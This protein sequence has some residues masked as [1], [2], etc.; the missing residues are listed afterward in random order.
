MLL[1]RLCSPP[2]ARTGLSS[3][4]GL[5]FLSSEHSI[6][7]TRETR[8]LS[9]VTK[10]MENQSPLLPEFA[11]MEESL[12]ELEA[13]QW[14]YD[15]TLRALGRDL[16][17]P[18]ARADFEAARDDLRG[19]QRVLA[20]AKVGLEER[21]QE[22]AQLNGALGARAQQKDVRAR[23]GDLGFGGDDFGLDGRAK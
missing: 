19:A 21:A 14:N 7:P 12:F 1:S 6:K 3:F 16:D 18:L 4:R 15:D 22:F 23:M 11:D 5:L 9:G 2:M 17:N 13:A 10:T 20:L 8:A